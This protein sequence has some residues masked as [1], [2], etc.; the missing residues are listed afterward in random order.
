[1]DT[2]DEAKTISTRATAKMTKDEVEMITTRAT[3]RVT[4]DKVGIMATRTAAK[5]RGLGE[6]RTFAAC[7]GG[8]SQ[9][10]TIGMGRPIEQLS[11]LSVNLPQHRWQ[12][13]HSYY[14]TWS[15]LIRY[16]QNQLSFL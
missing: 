5:M 4:K 3:A 7:L 16:E 1:M 6:M 11:L 10:D 12:E 13:L 14:F 8:A 15:T 9:A 2:R